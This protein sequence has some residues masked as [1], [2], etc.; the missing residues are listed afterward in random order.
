[1]LEALV[2][3]CHIT[4]LTLSSH[5]LIS[6]S[7]PHLTCLTP[8]PHLPWPP[9][10]PGPPPGERRPGLQGR[11]EPLRGALH[12]RVPRPEGLPRGG[13]VPRPR[14]T[15]PQG[16]AP[17]VLGTAQTASLTMDGRRESGGGGGGG[18]NNG[19]A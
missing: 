15:L 2:S 10:A 1:M 4:H 17:L 5:T 14:G 18:N 9:S 19:N 13:A 11:P 7:H 12:Q 16:H 8:S 6:Q 3:V